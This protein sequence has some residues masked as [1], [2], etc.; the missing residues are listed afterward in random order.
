MD[1]CW[2]K[3]GVPQPRNLLSLPHPFPIF[4]FFNY[5]STTK[6]LLFIVFFLF[7]SFPLSFL[8][9]TSPCLYWCDIPQTRSSERYHGLLR[10]RVILLFVLLLILLFFKLTF[11]AVWLKKNGGKHLEGASRRIKAIGGKGSLLERNGIYERYVTG[12][13]AVKRRE[14]EG[15]KGGKGGRSISVHFSGAQQTESK[16]QKETA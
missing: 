16:K 14:E 6:N 1:M 4:A 9:T 12:S 11:E 5:S 2:S 8:L 13:W 15:G 3:I 7:F 10:N